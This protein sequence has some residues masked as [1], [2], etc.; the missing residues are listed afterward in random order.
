MWLI[1]SECLCFGILFQCKH[2]SVRSAL[3]LLNCEHV[4]SWTLV[5]V[6]SLAY[7]WNSLV[8]QLLAFKN[9]HVLFR[10][11]MLGEQYCEMALI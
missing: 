7:I 11:L 2:V 9:S 3:V 1:S 4:T 5:Q 6:L 10:E 8:G